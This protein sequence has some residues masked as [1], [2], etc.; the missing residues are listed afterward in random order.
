MTLPERSGAS[1][2]TIAQI[3]DILREIRQLENFLDPDAPVLGDTEENVIAPGLES[4]LR[5]PSTVLTTISEEAR[6]V[7]FSFAIPIG[8]MEP[9]RH[10]ED[11]ETAYVYLGGIAPSS[12]DKGLVAPLAAKTFSALLEG[13]YSF[14]EADV[15]HREEWADKVEKNLPPDAIIKK[16]DHDKWL[17][18]PMRFLRVDLRKLSLD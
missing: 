11:S 8:Q 13:G 15:T 4:L 6:V 3:T 1:D 9:A 7:G 10:D 16:R 5:M 14:F 17:L 2:E 12:Q 18:G